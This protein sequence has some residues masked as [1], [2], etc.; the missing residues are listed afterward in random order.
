MTAFLGKQQYC[1][2][3]TPYT[4]VQSLLLWQ[5]LCDMSL[6]GNH[7]EQIS[8]SSSA[9]ADLPYDSHAFTATTSLY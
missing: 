3:N 9:I 4:A 6:L 1:E 7:L 5:D 2:T 8:L